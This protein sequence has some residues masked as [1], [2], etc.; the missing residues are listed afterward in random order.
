[1]VLAAHCAR[2]LSG[3]AGSDRRSRQRKPR[4][5]Y[6][7]PDTVAVPTRL[8]RTGDTWRLDYGEAAALTRIAAREYADDAQLI[9]D[10]ERIECWPMT[11]EESRRIRAARI[12]ETT[13]AAAHD[14]HRRAVPPD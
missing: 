8:M 12:V 13:T 5:S 14:N 2:R 7:A 11:V 9:A 4:N 6:R 1:M 10:L 3:I